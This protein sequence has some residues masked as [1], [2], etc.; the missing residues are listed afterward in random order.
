[1]APFEQTSKQNAKTPIVAAFCGTGLL[2]LFM[3]CMRS[4][5]ALKTF[6]IRK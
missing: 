2:T 4:I 5:I 1:M 3:I 6:I